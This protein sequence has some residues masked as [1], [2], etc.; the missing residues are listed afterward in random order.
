MLWVSLHL[1]CSRSCWVGLW[2]VTSWVPLAQQQLM[3]EKGILVVK[4]NNCQNSVL[5]VQI[6]KVGWQQR[7]QVG[8]RISKGNHESGGH[9]H[10]R[11]YSNVVFSVLFNMAAFCRLF[12]LLLLLTELVLCYQL[13]CCFVSNLHST[14][15]SYRLLFRL[16]FVFWAEIEYS[17]SKSHKD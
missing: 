12:I 14:C 17:H 7:L 16:V 2:S 1:K 8:V 3:I 6:P 9:Y 13:W 11:T 10:K 4:S 15:E 5:E